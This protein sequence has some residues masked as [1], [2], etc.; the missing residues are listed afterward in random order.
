MVEKF[1]NTIKHPATSR[2]GGISVWAVIAFAIVL[3]GY[4][5]NFDTLTND[6]QEIKPQVMTL[7]VDMAV[8][9]EKLWIQK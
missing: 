2:F 8:V 7:T 1:K 3:W 9:K 5:A 4:K 6:V